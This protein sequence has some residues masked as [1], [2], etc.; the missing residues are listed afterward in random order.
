MPDR[1]SR[2]CGACHVVDTHSHH[3]QFVAFEH[4]I[5]KEPT[6][7]SVTKHIQCCAAS[8]CPIC[9]TDVEFVAGALLGDASIGDAFTAAM[10]SKSDSHH[11]ALFDRHH[12]EST[13]YQRQPDS[14]LR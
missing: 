6:D 7:V 4:P 11:Q 12:V 13:N 2:E 1:I 3:V 8:G 14:V 9:Q 5:T 10:Q